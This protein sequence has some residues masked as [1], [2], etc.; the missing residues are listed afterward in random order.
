MAHNEAGLKRPRAK[1]PSNPRNLSMLSFPLLSHTQSL[2]SPPQIVISSIMC[3]FNKAEWTELAK[4]AE[5]SLC[6]A[7]LRTARSCEIITFSLR[8]NLALLITPLVV[9]V[10]PRTVLYRTNIYCYPKK[11]FI[12]SLAAHP[13]AKVGYI[14][15]KC[16]S[17]ATN[18]MLPRS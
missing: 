17:E 1:T 15:G 14:Y 2:F 5:V 8:D 12:E 13:G 4:M 10:P 6:Y 9:S 7:N 16:L 3:S 11:T 18:L